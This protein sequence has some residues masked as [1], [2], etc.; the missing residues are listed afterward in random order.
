VIPPNPRPMRLLRSVRNPVWRSPVVL[1]GV[2]CAPHARRFL[3]SSSSERRHRASGAGGPRRCLGGRRI[4]PGAPV[5]SCFCKV[6]D[7]RDSGRA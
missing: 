3:A 7:V 6:D 2:F 5:E 4:A 1:R